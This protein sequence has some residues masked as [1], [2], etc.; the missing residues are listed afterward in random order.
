MLG[1]FVGS[2]FTGTALFEIDRCR[3]KEGRDLKS[4]TVRE[5][6]DQELAPS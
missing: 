1:Y 3:R 2:E 5:I 6:L 4:V